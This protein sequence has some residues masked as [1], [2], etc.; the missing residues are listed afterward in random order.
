MYGGK[1]CFGKF[2]EIKECNVEFCLLLKSKYIEWCN[3]LDYC[4][5]YVFFD[6][7]IY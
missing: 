5:I 1:I 3:F 7:F 2:V 4:V 6:E